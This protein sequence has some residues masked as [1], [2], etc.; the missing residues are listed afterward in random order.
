ML[1]VPVSGFA[2]IAKHLHPG[3][4]VIG[5][6]PQEGANTLLSLRC[7]QRIALPDTPAT[8]ADGLGHSS[9]SPLTWA[10]N[11]QLLD[12][13]VTVTDNDI[14]TAMA[15]AF[16]HLKAVAE[17]SSARDVDGPTFHRLISQSAHPKEPSHA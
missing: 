11:S 7:G 16:R 17:P 4:K 1:V 12:T 14:T 5:V 3:I 15:F 13:V 2:T 6:E 10:F 8:I 9:P